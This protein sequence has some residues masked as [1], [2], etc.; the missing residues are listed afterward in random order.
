[1][2]PPRMAGTADPD[3]ASMRIEIVPPVKRIAT[4]GRVT[5]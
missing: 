1:M 2:S 4:V 5:P 3:R